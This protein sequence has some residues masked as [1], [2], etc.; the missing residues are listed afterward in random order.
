MIF[1]YGRSTATELVLLAGGLKGKSMI[2]QNINTGAGLKEHFDIAVPGGGVGVLNACDMQWNA[3][4]DGWGRRFGG[5]I[6][7]SECDD[8]LPQPLRKGCYFRFDFLR[9]IM[10]PNV[11]YQEVVCPRELTQRTECIRQ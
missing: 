8:L 7:R 2:V 6:K 3:P 9:G 4:H 1:N 5:I 11:T 10:N